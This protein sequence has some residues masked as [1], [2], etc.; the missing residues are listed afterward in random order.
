MAA[1]EHA[2]EQGQ[3]AG[4]YILHHLTFWQNH[5]AANVVDFSVFN[6]DSLIY[7]TLIGVPE[8]R[9][10]ADRHVLVEPNPALRGSRREI[11]LHA[12]AFEHGHAAIL[13]FYRQGNGEA[14]PRILGP[15]PNR[16]RQV[17]RIGRLIELPARHFKHVGIVEGGNDHF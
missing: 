12:I 5:K 10:F 6:Y 9:D 16:I 13:P 3:T 15:I 11:V 4:E 2:A 14:A 7:G 8:R 1:A 17:D